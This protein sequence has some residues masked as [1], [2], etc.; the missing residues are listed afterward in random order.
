MD[1]ATR[2]PRLFG[3]PNS[4]SE[5]GFARESAA[6]TRWTNR[7]EQFVRTLEELGDNRQKLERKRFQ[8]ER[9]VI[10]QYFK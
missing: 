4:T 7:Q 9:D 8:V 3:E 2:P 10:G 6:G 1:S 5:G